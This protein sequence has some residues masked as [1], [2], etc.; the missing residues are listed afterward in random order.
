[1]HKAHGKLIAFITQRGDKFRATIGMAFD[2]PGDRDS[3]ITIQAVQPLTTNLADAQLQ[4]MQA[5][6]HVNETM[7]KPVDHDPADMLWYS[8]IEAAQKEQ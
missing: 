3:F 2:S 5:A 4:V 7:S 8:V 6:E 1:M